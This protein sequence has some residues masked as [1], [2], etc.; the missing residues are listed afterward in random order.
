M[1]SIDRTE[2]L[3]QKINVEISEFLQIIGGLSKHPDRLSVSRPDALRE[4]QRVLDSVGQI[5][6]KLFDEAKILQGQLHLFFD[7][8]SEEM[9]LKIMQSALH[10]KHKVREI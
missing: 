5:G 8:P 1:D 9:R 4:M 2:Q 3:F 7:R 10:I 6:G